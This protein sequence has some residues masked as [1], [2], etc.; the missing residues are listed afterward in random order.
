M[1]TRAAP[2]RT[3]RAASA[4][5]A[6]KLDLIK[7]HRAEYVAPRKPVLIA[8]A[9]AHYLVVNGRGSPGGACFESRIGALYAMAFTIKMTRKFA[10]QGDYAVSRLECRYPAH[11]DG[12]PE[13]MDQLE[14]QL[15]IRTPDFVGP[16]DLEAAVAALRKRGKEGDASHVSL[17]RIDEGQVVQM[18][19]VGPY[20]R[21]GETLEVM[22][23]FANERGLVRAGA[24]HE[25]YISD[26]RRVAPDK[27]K[28][29]LRLPVRPRG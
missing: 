20:D 3:A 2:T 12:L 13:D 27:L 28:T 11:Q 24:H 9:P 14:W 7:L 23:A 5:P 18:L 16:G 26:P 15:L 6:A 1:K 10:G 4:A 17:A 29:I 21:E 8:T 25:I 22:E 19:H